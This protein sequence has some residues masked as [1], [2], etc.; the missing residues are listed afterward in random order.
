MDMV[1]ARP[2]FIESPAYNLCFCDRPLYIMQC[3]EFFRQSQRLLFVHKEQPCKHRRMLSESLNFTALTFINISLSVC[4]SQ[5]L[6]VL[7]PT[8]S[9]F[10]SVLFTVAVAFC[11]STCLL[12]FMYN[13]I[14]SY[15]HFCIDMQRHLT[16]ILKDVNSP[17]KY[18]CCTFEDMYFVCLHWLLIVAKAVSR[19]T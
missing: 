6:P 10:L 3:A 9:S 19:F 7:N 11:F 4:L 5:V 15:L 17:T 2:T 12:N 18:F 13:K 14:Y 16:Y 8:L 1:K